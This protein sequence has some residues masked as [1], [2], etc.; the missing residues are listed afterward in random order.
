MFDLIPVA[1]EEDNMHLHEG[2]LEYLEEMQDSVSFSDYLNDIAEPTDV[3][4][5]PELYVKK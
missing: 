1:Y 2:Y 4:W 3:F 5:Y